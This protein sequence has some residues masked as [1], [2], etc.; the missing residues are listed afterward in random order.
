MIMTPEEHAEAAEKAIKKASLTRYTA[1]ENLLHATIAVANAV[2]TAAGM[3]AQIRDQLN[4]ANELT[5]SDPAIS[6][7]IATRQIITEM[8]A[9]LEGAEE[10]EEDEPIPD[11]A[12]DTER[13]R[14]N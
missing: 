8:R 2:M 4:M 7:V 5:A 13:G 11:I 9:Q 14:A 6:H 10:E 1:E 12:R 3:L